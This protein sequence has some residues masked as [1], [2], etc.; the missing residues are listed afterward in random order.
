MAKRDYYEILGIARGANEQE[1]KSAFRRLAKECHPDRNPGDK[2]A[3][4]QLQGAERGLRGPEGSAEARGLRPVRPCRLRRRHGR[5]G[6]RLR[7]RLRILDVG[8]FRRSVRRVHGR[9]A[10]RARPR[11]HRPRAR[12]RPSLQP[13]NHARRGLRR[14]D[15]ADPRADAASPARPA[16]APAP[17]PARSR[18]PARPAAAIGKVRASQGFFTI[19]RTCPTCQGRGEMIDDP[20]A[21]CR[22]S[23]RVHQGA[24]ALGQHSGGRRGRHAH[25]ARGRRR[26][27]PARR[28]GRRPLHLP[29]DQAAR[30]LPARR[31]RHLLQGADLDDDG[32]ARRPDRGAD[33]R[34]HGNAREGSRKAPRA[35][36][37]S[38]C[39]GKGMPVL[40]SKVT[41][42]MYIQVEVETPKNLTRTPARA[43]RRVRARE[44]QGD[45]P[46][47]RRL[48]RARQGILRRQ[49]RRKTRP[50]SEQAKTTARNAL[51]MTHRPPRLLFFAGSARSASY[52]KKLA[53]TW[54]HDRRRERHPGDLR[55][56]RRLPDADLQRRSRSGRGPARERAQAQ[57]ADAGP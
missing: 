33:G 40:R 8:H 47:E 1:L 11:A 29:V 48:L 50:P 4:Q 34:W 41:G 44:P 55:R 10:R 43:A 39:K 25:P 2:D 36:S 56:P 42:D 30:V 7:A 32:G 37:S 13:G 54:C 28:P 14:Q 51:A 20:C 27:R 53:R 5:G 18:R 19:E 16:R 24:H 6:A 3:E 21:D 46:G 57:G 45:E 38:A 9:P 49:G 12:R 31:R 17:S 35:A 26:G 52:N 23:G 15:G 22:G